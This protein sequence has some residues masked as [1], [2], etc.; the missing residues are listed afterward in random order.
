MKQPVLGIVALI[1]VIIVSL[2]IISLF[3]EAVFSSW[4]SFFFMCLVPIQ[5]VMAMVWQTNYPPLL[6]GMPQPAKG[7]IMTLISI[8]VAAC[9]AAFAFFIVG[10]GH[11]P[12]PMVIFYVILTIALTFWFA[13][14][15]QCWPVT[16]F[17]SNPLIIGISVLLVAYLGGYVI[18]NIFYDFSFL[19]GAPVYFADAD[20]GGLFNAW[21]FMVLLVTSVATIMILPLFEGW[22]VRAIKNPTVNVIVSSA[23][24]LTLAYSFY[25][26]GVYV[27]GMDQIIFM[28]MVPVSFLFGTFLPLTF[29]Q[30]TLLKDMQ[31]PMK[32][33]ILFIFAAISAFILQQL[34]LI[35]GPMVS[36]PLVAGPEGNYQKE[37]WL[38]NALLG[39]TFPVLVIML[40]Y[41]QFWPMAAKA[42]SESDSAE[43]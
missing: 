33:I 3:E 2:G 11:G 7:L 35:L 15:W 39:L 23:L 8:A 37:L 28:I 19:Q 13:A 24:V 31:Q 25:C 10:K 36:G 34:Y 20:P 42:K 4:V 21:D 9:V 14:L 1:V 32:G 27:F 43:E 6:N 22:P 40:D 18:F 12:T 26:I 30:G 41:F 5:L 38:S 29:F 17:T 16:L